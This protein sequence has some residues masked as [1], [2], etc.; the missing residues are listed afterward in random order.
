MWLHLKHWL[1]NFEH[2]CDHP[3]AAL[4]LFR[5]WTRKKWTNPQSMFQMRSHL[6]YSWMNT[7]L[8]ECVIHFNFQIS[9]EYCN[10]PTVAQVWLHLKHWLAN[11]EPHC[12]HP[13]AALL[14]FRTWTRKKWTNP[15]SM[16][17]MRS[18]LGYSWMNATLKLNLKVWKQQIMHSLRS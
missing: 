10:H 11:F 16:F 15:Q 13:T 8:M 12:D 1:A 17:Q 18:P 6:G 4:L 9:F 2:H 7:T 5:T 14:L 3:T